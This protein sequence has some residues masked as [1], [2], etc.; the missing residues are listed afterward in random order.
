MSERVY[1][2]MKNSF[3]TKVYII[4]ILNMLCHAIYMSSRYN[5]KIRPYTSCEVRN[6]CKCVVF[7]FKV[8]CTKLNFLHFFVIKS[9]LRSIQSLVCYINVCFQ[10]KHLNYK[11]YQMCDESYIITYQLHL[12]CLYII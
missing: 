2:R 11:N 12:C 5:L 4:F 10:Q 3:I 1:D 8:R 7:A 9:Y 6:T